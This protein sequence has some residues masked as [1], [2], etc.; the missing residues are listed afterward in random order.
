MRTKVIIADSN[1][2]TSKGL[3]TLLE[4][5]ND[6]AVVAEVWDKEEL[7]TK[8][9]FYH[10][11][12]LIIDFSTSAFKLDTLQL[13]NKKYA[14]IRI[15]AIT[16]EINSAVMSKALALGITSYVLKDCDKDEIIEALQKTVLGQRFLCGKI[17]DRLLVNSKVPENTFSSSISCEGIN[18]TDR[19]I[20][21]VKYIAEGYSNK[22]IAT[23]LYLSNHTVT[24]HRKNIMSKLRVN[25]TAGVVMF[26]VREN[27]LNPNK[28]LFS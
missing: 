23:K 16:P 6:Y 22:E 28:F 1:Y 18:I 20:E 4:E 25:N 2:L 17:I 11:D 13:L 7:E 10:P 3:L 12:V 21:I 14:S 19:E 9:K 5:V 27:L 8:I 15:L 24:T 26:A